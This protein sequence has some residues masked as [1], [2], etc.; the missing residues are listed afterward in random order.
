MQAFVRFV[1]SW[2][3]SPFGCLVTVA[4]CVF[5]FTSHAAEAVWMEPGWVLP[6][7]IAVLS[8]TRRKCFQPNTGGD[9][10]SLPRKV[11]SVSASN[12]GAF[13]RNACVLDNAPILRLSNRF[14]RC[15]DVTYP[16]PFACFH[17]R[18]VTRLNLQIQMQREWIFNSES[19]LRGCVQI[20]R[21]FASVETLKR[22]IT[23]KGK[24]TGKVEN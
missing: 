9:W 20:C 24:R 22:I 1:V 13:H 18:R 6:A 21:G 17:A 12:N 19:S 7:V 5:A 10:Q 14:F 16:R 15:F 3:V 23:S 2:S 8:T 11:F 4:Q